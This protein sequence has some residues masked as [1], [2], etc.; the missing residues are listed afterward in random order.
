MRVL[1]VDDSQVTRAIISQ[2][3]LHKKVYE[4]TFARDGEEAKA[5]LDGV[6]VLITDWVMPRTDGLALTRWIRASERY[7]GLPILMVTAADMDE[8]RRRQAREAGVDLF[9]EKTF[10]PDDIHAAV[11]RVH[12]LGRRP[13]TP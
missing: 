5:C 4:L 6:E 2:A 13:R 10:A 12:A 11:Q 3:L 8:A 7:R 1:V 9:I